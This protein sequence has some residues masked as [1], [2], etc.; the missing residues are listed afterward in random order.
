MDSRPG[1][2]PGRR[3][4]RRHGVRDQADAGAPDDHPRP[5][6][7]GAAAWVAGDEVYG[8]GPGLRA[9]LETRQVGY[10]LAVAKATQVNIGAGSF[11]ADNLAARLPRR[12]RDRVCA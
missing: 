3:H 10:V 6:R 12:R 1:P 2:V 7:R 8:A 4:P 5:G 11:R 9:D